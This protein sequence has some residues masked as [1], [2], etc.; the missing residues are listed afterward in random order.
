VAIGEQQ[1][2]ADAM[3][4]CARRRP[5]PTTKTLSVSFS[6][7]ARA[8]DDRPAAKM[9]PQQTCLNIRKMLV[10]EPY[11]MGYTASGESLEN[12]PPRAPMA[13]WHQND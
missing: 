9:I 8:G 12:L 3:S 5:R 6:V 7:A 1:V 13:R 2:A 4:R 11:L 10:D